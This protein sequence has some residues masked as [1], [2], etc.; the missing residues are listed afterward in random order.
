MCVCFL[1]VA[2]A[3]KALPELVNIITAGSGVGY[4]CDDTLSMACRTANSLF[5]KEPEAG[6]RLLNITLMNALKNLSQSE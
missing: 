4:E 6:K 3:R 2:E 1:L 5:V